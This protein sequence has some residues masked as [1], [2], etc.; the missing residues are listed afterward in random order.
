[1][2]MLSR[3]TIG[4][5]ASKKA[6]LSAPVARPML[7]ASEAAVSGPVATMVRPAAGSASTFSR[8]I[9]MFGMRLER[10][11]HLAAE[12]LAVDRHR[13]ARG[14]PRHFARAH[15]Q[16]IEP[17]HL[18]VEQADR[19]VLVIVGAEAVRADQLGEPVGL[20]RRG[21]RRRRRASRTA[22]P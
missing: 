20:V 2:S 9:S 11:L 22:A 1:M 8:T 19:I 4:A 18:V 6:R 14:H 15:D 5:I 16:R 21:R 10:A 17:P 12:H 7:S 3:W 13:R